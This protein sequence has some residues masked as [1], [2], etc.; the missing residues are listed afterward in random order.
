[1][2]EWMR[3]VALA[4]LLSPLT[5][6]IAHADPAA[7]RRAVEALE[8]SY[9]MVL[10]EQ[11]FEAYAA[12]FHPDYTHWADGGVVRD[13]ATF[14][15]SVR[16]WYDAG[17]RATAVS[18]KPI[19]TDLLGDYAL[20][21]YEL[22]EDFSNGESFVGRFTSVVRRHKGRWLGY[23]TSFQTLYYGSTVSAPS[24]GRGEAR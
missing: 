8:Q 24:I 5:V 13:R 10:A 11:G 4:L 22:R 20:A 1:M 23:R 2:I 7:D 14:L 21:R 18:M 6:P 9:A 16:R 17:N 19:S 3:C 15:A 12:L